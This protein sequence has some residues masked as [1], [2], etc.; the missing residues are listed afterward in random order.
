MGK[1]WESIYGEETAI[2]HYPV[3]LRRL[4]AFTI[5][6]DT[7]GSTPRLTMDTIIHQC[8]SLVSLLPVLDVNASQMIPTVGGQYKLQFPG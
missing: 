7:A 6:L 5:R 4:R 2:T 3:C 8:L 1:E